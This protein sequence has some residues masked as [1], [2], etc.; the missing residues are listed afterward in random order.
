MLCHFFSSLSSLASL[1][2]S[3][4]RYTAL[5][6]P[7]DLTYLNILTLSFNPLTSV[8]FPAGIRLL[9]SSV[10]QLRQHGVTVTLFPRVLFPQRAP[11]GDFAF[12][13]FADVG[14]FKVQ[15]SKNL[16]TWTEIGSITVASPNLPGAKFTDSG[17]PA[18]ESRF[19]RV[20]Q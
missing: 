18:S 10:P 3:G 5:S 14:T 19:Y 11:N 16:K 1:R 15:R 2:L 20:Q 8:S 7:R 6:I 4:N 17:A 13:L 9:D 12:E